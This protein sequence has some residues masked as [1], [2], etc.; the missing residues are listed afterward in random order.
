[1][2]VVGNTSAW[3]KGEG[4]IFAATRPLMCAVCRQV[5]ATD[6][7][8]AHARVIVQ[9][10][11][12]GRTGDENLGAVRCR[13]ALA[14]VVVDEPRGLVEAVGHRSKKMDTAEIF[15]VSVWN[16]CDRWPPWGRSRPMIPSWGLSRPVYTRKLAGEPERA[17]T[18]TPHGVEADAPSASLA[19]RLR[20]VDE[21]TVVARAGV[22]LGVLVGHDGTDSLR[23]SGM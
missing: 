8:S 11:V 15:F 16:P 21:L 9:A 13:E 10:R 23:R 17:C 22:A 1:M 2:C 12:R 5:R 18:L 4:I 3:S 6:P 20:L 14:R 7:Q 19:Q